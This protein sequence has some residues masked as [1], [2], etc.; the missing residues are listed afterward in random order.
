MRKIS[1]SPGLPLH[2]GYRSCHKWSRRPIV[3]RDIENQH[4]GRA[5]NWLPGQFVQ[6]LSNQP[7]APDY[8]VH[9][10]VYKIPTESRII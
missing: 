2:E 7:Q 8:E 9:G 10:L 4:F 6:P 3:A 5:P 1:N